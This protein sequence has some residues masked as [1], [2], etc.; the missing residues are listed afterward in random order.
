MELDS[1]AG[2]REDRVD[3]SKLAGRMTQRIYKPVMFGTLTSFK[4]GKVG[5]P[6]LGRLLRAVGEAGASPPS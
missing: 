1:A 2:S 3:A 6:P 5:L 4:V